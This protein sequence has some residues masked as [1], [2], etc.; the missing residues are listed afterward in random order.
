MA[1]Y[2][3]PQRNSR[4]MVSKFLEHVHEE[5]VKVDKPDM[6]SELEAKIRAK[7]IT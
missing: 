5:G 7:A 6:V 4:I 3:P 2:E 1:V